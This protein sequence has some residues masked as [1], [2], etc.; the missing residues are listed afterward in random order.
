MSLDYDKIQI[1]WN[2]GLPDDEIETT[3][4]L[5]TAYRRQGD[6]VQYSALKSLGL[7]D[8]ARLEAEL[9]QMA[10]EQAL[11]MPVMLSSID[12]NKGVIDDDGADE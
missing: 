8:K 6:Y 1:T 7:T 9:E 3:D 11:S 5:V 2:D 4:R 12:S 10:E